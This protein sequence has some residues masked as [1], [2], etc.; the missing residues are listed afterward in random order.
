MCD[1]CDNAGDDALSSHLHPRHVGEIVLLRG[2]GPASYKD[3]EKQKTIN[4]RNMQR[5]LHAL[6]KNEH[7]LVGTV[8]VFL[9]L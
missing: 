7:L 6:P 2:P 8:C 3:N 4:L 9:K 5:V 1:D